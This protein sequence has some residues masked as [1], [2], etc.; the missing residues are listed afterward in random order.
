MSDT[1]NTNAAKFTTYST[2][3]EQY[4][5]AVGV[6]FAFAQERRIAELEQRLELWGTNGN[7]ERVRLPDHLDGIATREQTIRLLEERIAK[8]ERGEYIWRNGRWE[9][10]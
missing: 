9:L 10:R 2:R 1:P 7:G 5:E 4:I 3:H 8:L 6:Q